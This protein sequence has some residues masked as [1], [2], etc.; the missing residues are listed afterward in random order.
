MIKHIF[1]FETQNIT[2]EKRMKINEDGDTFFIEYESQKTA[3]DLDALSDNT[4][5]SVVFNAIEGSLY[6]LY[7]FRELLEVFNMTASEFCSRTGLQGIMQIDKSHGDVFIKIFMPDEVGHI[8]SDTTDFS[9]YA[10]VP[11]SKMHGLDLNFS[12]Q[13]RNDKVSLDGDELVVSLDFCRTKFWREAVYVNYAGQYV[14]LKKGHNEI[15]F[16]Y[17]PYNEIFVGKKNC[18]YMG[19][20]IEMES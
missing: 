1:L 11:L 3:V 17:V 16:K 7:N 13:V 2:A 18:R 14:K 6:P 10:V 19:R 15:R 5:T 8:D 12:W 4:S 20:R 9:Q